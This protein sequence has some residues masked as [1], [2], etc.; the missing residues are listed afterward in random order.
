MSGGSP[1]ALA[2]SL[3]SI[4]T[5]PGYG[6]SATVKTAADGSFS[7]VTPDIGTANPRVDFT[8]RSAATPYLAAAQ[9]VV[10]L[11]INQEAEINLFSGDLTAYR[12]VRFFACG[13]LPEPLADVLLVG[14]LEYQYSRGPD[15]PWNT[16]GTGKLVADG[17]C[18]GDQFGGTYTAS[19][20]A[21]LA[22]AYYRA[23]APAVAGQEAAVS[24]VIHLQR[25]PTRI[26]GFSITPR[27]VSR[28]GEVVV[29]GR[30]WRLI[31]KWSPDAGQRIVIELRYRHKTFTL[32]TRLTTNS[33]GRFRGTFAVPRT[34]AWRALYKGSKT[35]FATATRAINVRVR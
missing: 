28:G 27:R 3:L 23:Y 24:Q 15:G 13:G 7:Y 29:S 5:P 21:P 25:F 30:L 4:T 26:T 9:L 19:L 17:P 33:A 32:R 35:Q 1:H 34:A 10:T 18:F 6:I 11:H 12:M 14:P 8:V 16:L 20:K 31:R 2:N 22:N